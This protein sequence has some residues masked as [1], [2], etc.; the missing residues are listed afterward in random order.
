[1]PYNHLKKHHKAVPFLRRMCCV[2][3]HKSTAV[4]LSCRLLPQSHS[5]VLWQNRHSSQDTKTEDAAARMRH[6]KPCTNIDLVKRTSKIETSSKAKTEE[7]TEILSVIFG[8]KVQTR[9]Q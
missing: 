2:Y 8:K 5:R 6:N 1:M 9:M 3:I 7:L 4:S